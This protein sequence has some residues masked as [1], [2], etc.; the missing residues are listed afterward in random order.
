MRV[1]KATRIF[2]LSKNINIII[3]KIK[4]FYY[5]IFSFF[6]WINHLF[7]ENYL[8]GQISIQ[9]LLLIRLLF[10]GILLHIPQYYD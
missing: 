8:Q 1:A 9:A 7:Q 4:I 5:I 2:F 10:Y 6:L 3:V